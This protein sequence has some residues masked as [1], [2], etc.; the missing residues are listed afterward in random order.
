MSAIS[1][2]DNQSIHKP[3]ESD[4]SAIERKNNA[5]PSSVKKLDSKLKPINNSNTRS[6]TTSTRKESESIKAASREQSLT[7]NNSSK[8][9]TKI[10][11]HTINTMTSKT[12]SDHRYC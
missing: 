9:L 12:V 8:I 5:Y 6:S 7:N 10:S 3:R 1:S 4:N 2:Q 11:V